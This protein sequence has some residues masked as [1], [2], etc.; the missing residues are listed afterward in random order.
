MVDV[1]QQI[2]PFFALIGIGTA[3]GASG[4]FDAGAGKVLTDFV[5]YFALSAL[6]FRFSA[7]LDLGALFDPAVIAAYA[8]AS[9]CVYAASP[10]ASATTGSALRVEGGIVESIA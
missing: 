6:L 10:Q 7:D 4:M 9:L 2:L 1:L 5:F 8:G 3:A